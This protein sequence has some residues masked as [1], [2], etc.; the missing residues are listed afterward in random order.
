MWITSQSFFK[1]WNIFTI[2]FQI[3]F[4]P[5]PLWASSYS[6]IIP[7]NIVLLV[8]DALVIFFSP[9]LFLQ[10]ISFAML[11][12]SVNCSSVSNHLLSPLINYYMTLYYFIAKFYL[13]PFSVCVP[14]ITLI[15][16]VMFSFKGLS[17][18]IHFWNL[19]LLISSF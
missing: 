18:C 11:S 19:C 17:I 16:V 13:V 5:W 10:F 7:Q 3:F 6:K 2:I 15:I 9:L 4:S 14:S 12:S 1:N 8:T